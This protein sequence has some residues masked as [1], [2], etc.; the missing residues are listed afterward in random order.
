MPIW[1]G[2]NVSSC[3]WYWQRVTLLAAGIFAGP[4][5]LYGSLARLDVPESLVLYSIDGRDFAP[6]E[7]PQTAEKFYNYPVLGKLSIDDAEGVANSNWFEFVHCFW[8]RHGIRM[9]S[10]G[11]TIDLVICFECNR[12][13]LY[14]GAI[15]THEPISDS[16]IPLLNRHLQGAGIPIAPKT[17]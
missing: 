14:S 3:Y 12:L 5:I 11:E 9:I 16:P 15:E 4:R 17:E 13:E 6:G 1:A 10:Q 8:P 7:E 2:G